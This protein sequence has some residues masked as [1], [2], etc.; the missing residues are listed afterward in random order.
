MLLFI[1]RTVVRGG[2]SQISEWC[3]EVTDY[4]RAT[5]S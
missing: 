4:S 1:A 3:G 2:D 5:I